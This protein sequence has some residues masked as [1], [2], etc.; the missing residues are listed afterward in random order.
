MTD[1]VSLVEA[2]GAMVCEGARVYLEEVIHADLCVVFLCAFLN[3]PF[4]E[5]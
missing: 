3:R 2:D 5:S 4:A 1:D